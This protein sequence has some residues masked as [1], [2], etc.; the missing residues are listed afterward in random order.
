LSSFATRAMEFVVASP[1]RAPT[2]MSLDEKSM[3][4]AAIATAPTG[5]L[6]WPSESVPAM[7]MLI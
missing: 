3:S 5:A 4:G 1:T 7:S 2:W 6:V